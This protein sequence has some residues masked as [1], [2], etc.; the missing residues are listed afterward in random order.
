MPI[1]PK[2][3]DI[4]KKYTRPV[5]KE[6]KRDIDDT[7]Q[8]KFFN[9]RR[10]RDFR[11]VCLSKQ[12]ICEVSLIEHKVVEANNIHHLIKW[13]TAF[14]DDL[15]R[16]ELLLD[17]DNVIAISSYVHQSIHYAPERLTEAQKQYIKEKKDAVYAKYIKR[18]IMINYTED[19]NQLNFFGEKNWYK[20]NFIR[21]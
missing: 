20:K 8:H 21:I 18:G 14:D 6:P 1:I 9:S 7:A 10:Y 16:Y 19:R 17:P 12:P 15:I 2:L 11:K 4:K 5:A 3:S 13:F